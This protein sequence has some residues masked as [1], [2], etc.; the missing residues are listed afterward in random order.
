MGPD[1]DEGLGEETVAFRAEADAAAEEMAEQ[2]A[3]A[4]AR[5]DEAETARTN[6]ERTNEMPL[7]PRPA[8]MPPRGPPAAEADGRRDRAGS[9]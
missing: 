8:G 2:R 3:A 4:Q 5:V 7:L 1:R 9:C 6:A